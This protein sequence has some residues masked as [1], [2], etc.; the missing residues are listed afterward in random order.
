MIDINTLDDTNFAFYKDQLNKVETQ[1]KGS[2]L[3]KLELVERITSL[4]EKLRLRLVP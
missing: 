2:V 4:E 3:E 1:L